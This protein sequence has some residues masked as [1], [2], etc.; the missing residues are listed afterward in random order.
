MNWKGLRHRCEYLAFRLLACALSMLSVRATVRF[1]E[2]MA[3]LL[4]RVLPRKLTRYNVASD[5]LRAA[6]G[7]G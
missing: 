7:D 3:W 6:F 5:N 1:A 2:S 4:T